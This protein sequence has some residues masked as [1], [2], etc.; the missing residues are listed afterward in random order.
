MPFSSGTFSL[1]SGNPVVSGTTISSTWA[2][3]TLSDIATGLSTCVLKDG[4]QTI[5]GNIPMSGFI[6]TGLGAGAASGNSLRYEQVNGVVTTGGDLLY[7]SGAGTLARLSAGTTGMALTVNSSGL[8]SWTSVINL[9]T[10]TATTSGTAINYT[11]IPATA[12]KITIMFKGVSTSGNDPTYIQIGSGSG[13][14]TSGYLSCSTALSSPSTVSPTNATAGFIS[15]GSG[16]T[17]S[18]VHGT[19][20]LSLEN[21]SAFTWVIS[22]VLARSDAA[23]NYVCAGSKSLS[24]VLDRVRITTS[25]GTDTFDA[26]EIN[27]S[28]E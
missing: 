8:P 23:I 26:G 24:A 14:E 1:A 25:G 9:Q 4:S 6:F 20:F 7:A 27:I 15:N 22:G 5:T 17:N 11:G 18:I 10:P 13:I 3:N 2:N 28:Y 12:K 19:L 21:S 16:G